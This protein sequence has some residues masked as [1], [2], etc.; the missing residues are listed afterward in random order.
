M[1]KSKITVC[2]EKY[3]LFS[4]E[5]RDEAFEILK[6]ELSYKSIFLMPGDSSDFKLLAYDLNKEELSEYYTSALC[7]AAFLINKRG[8]PF[9]EV[10][11]ETPEGKIEIF[12]TDADKFSVKITK[13]KQLLS[14]STEIFGCEIKYRDLLVKKK[15]RAIHTDD[16][17]LISDD[18]LKSLVLVDDSLPC[19]VLASAS[20]NGEL[21]VRYYSDFISESVSPLLLYSAAAFN[22]RIIS[23][24]S[25]LNFV[26]EKERIFILAEPFSVTVAVQPEFI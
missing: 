10:D 9:S 15:F 14:Y 22:E 20:Q 21:A 2:T 24:G 13:C 17:L 1:T 12:Y 3:E 11:F 6:K 5:N 4:V 26:A 7:A 19:G 25:A 8:L 23:G 16:I 18:I